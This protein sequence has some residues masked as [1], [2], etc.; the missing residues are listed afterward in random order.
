[1]VFKFGGSS[2]ADAGRL[3]TVAELVRR[4]AAA[5]GAPPVVVVSA[6]GD[7]TDRLTELLGSRAGSRD[8]LLA[9]L[10]DR[11][12]RAFR[13]VAVSGSGTDGALSDRAA[14]ATLTTALDRVEAVRAGLISILPDGPGTGGGSA[15]DVA[16]V[17]D[18]V[19]AAGEDLSVQGMALA[20]TAA[21]MTARV[22]D[23]REVIRTDD[24]FGFARPDEAAIRELARTRLLPPLEQGVVPILQGFVGGTQDG[25]TTT[26]GRG[27]SDLTASLLGAALDATVHIWT[28]VQGVLSADPGV[29]ET[30]RT[31]DVV[32]FE[33]AVELAYFGARVLHPGAAKHAVSRQVPV[34]IRSTFQPEHRGTLILGD[35]WGGPEI[36]AVASKPRVALIKVRGRPTALPYGFLARVFEILA[37]HRLPVDLVATSH[38]STAFTVDE[39]EEIGAVARELEEVAEVSVRTGLATVTVVGNGLLRQ[40]GFDARVFG[41]V[42][43]TPIHLVSQA[44]DVSLSLVVDASDAPGLVRRLHAT[45]VDDANLV[46]EEPTT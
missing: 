27:G 19:L 20:L 43:R 1:M 22:V 39:S 8:R 46:T 41:T 18:R 36:A 13:E 30:P 28:D 42:A 4:E 14:G 2:V 21:G 23:A 12:L 15:S 6:M 33:E 10:A 5:S 38:T 26:L 3:A 16:A 45:L 34:R 17:T 24:R 29:V 32:G 7:T 44:S 37:R 25:R 9:A 35:R 40:P 31:L 11:H